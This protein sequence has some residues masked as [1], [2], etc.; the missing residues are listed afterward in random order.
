MSTK[1]IRSIRIIRVQIFL[2]EIKKHPDFPAQ[3]LT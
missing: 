2:R 1:I 3:M